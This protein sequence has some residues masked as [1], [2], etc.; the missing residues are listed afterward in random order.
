MRRVDNYRDSTQ[1]PLALG[2]MSAQI[3]LLPPELRDLIAITLAESMDAIPPE[4]AQQSFAATEIIIVC[5]VKGSSGSSVVSSI[6]IYATAIKANVIGA[7]V[8]PV[9]KKLPNFSDSTEGELRIII[10]FGL[11][12]GRT[13]KV[14]PTTPELIKAMNDFCAQKMLEGSEQKVA[15]GGIRKILSALITSLN[16]RTWGDD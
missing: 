1:L 4:Y 3:Q 15:A 9:T 5:A 6:G 13:Q 7:Q 2:P 8:D 11:N 10:G 12:A 16:P 14:V